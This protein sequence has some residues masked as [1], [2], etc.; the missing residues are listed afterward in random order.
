MHLQLKTLD[1][2]FKKSVI[3]IVYINLINLFLQFNANYL[4]QYYYQYYSIEI[5]H[6]KN[7]P[8]SLL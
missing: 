6:K 8:F 5:K 7:F 2:S 3:A 1:K 4:Y